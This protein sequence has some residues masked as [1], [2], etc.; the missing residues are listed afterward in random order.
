MY[1]KLTKEVLIEEIFDDDDR[2]LSRKDFLN[3]DT[4]TWT[5]SSTG[6]LLEYKFNDSLEILNIYDSEDRL[7]HSYDRGIIREIEYNSISKIEHIRHTSST[8]IIDAYLKYDKQ[9][10]E[11]ENNST[12]IECEDVIYNA[13]A[14]TT[15]LEDGSSIVVTI[16]EN[17]VIY[18]NKYDCNNNL[19]YS[20]TYNDI[21]ENYTKKYYIYSHE[22]KLI[23]IEEYE[24]DD[25]EEELNKT[26]I[27]RINY[28][29]DNRGNLIR[30][31]CG[32]F[33][34][35]YEYDDQNRCIRKYDNYGE[36]QWF[37]YVEE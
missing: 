27:K 30:Y 14:L 12:V 15:Y 1:K 5:Y 2:I 31:K 34:E 4:E 35:N 17:T 3:N 32:S 6:K 19:I 18:I 26:L 11:I 36:S 9:G 21:K 13:A 37:D 8:Q 24:M 7:I 16:V 20:V 33:I 29:Y 28:E 22:N 10:R 25:I 23:L